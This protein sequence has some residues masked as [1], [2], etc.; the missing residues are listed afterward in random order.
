[1][2]ASD[3]LPRK[4]IPAGVVLCLLISASCTTRL[5]VRSFRVVPATPTY[6]LRLPDSVEIPFPETL[7]LYNGFEPTR[8]W[9]D[10]RPEM[11][12]RIEN[13]YYRPR[14]ARR[15]LHGFLGT[16][17]A[18]YRVRV[19]GRLQLL[20]VQSIKHRPND[21]PAVQRLIATSQRHYRYHRFYYEIFFRGSNNARGSVLLGA[22]TQQE[23]DRLATELRAD[24]HTVCG[25][26]SVICTVFPEEC[27]VSI[28]MEIFVNGAPRDVAWDSDLASVV[29]HPQHIELLRL[30]DG[31]LTPVKLN[32]HDPG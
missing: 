3:Q 5:P 14:M 27:S 12:L 1:M 11:E 25:E 20:S 17:V 16:E 32:P 7:R 26:R 30:Y 18:R 9:M 21:Q 4:G 24:P 2:I 10:L 19:N 22:N 29:D 31:R 28:E 8:G 13:A 6:F 15:G 23:L